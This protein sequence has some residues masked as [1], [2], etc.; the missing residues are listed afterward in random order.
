MV[1][2]AVAPAVPAGRREI[3]AWDTAGRPVGRLDYQLCHECRFGYIGNIAVA[4]GWRGHG[5]A[6]EMLHRALAHAPDHRWSTSRQTADGR[7][8]FAAMTEETAVH[9]VQRG[10]RC[11]HMTGRPVRV[12][13]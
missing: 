10:A 8:F 4:D 11:P 12:R 5:L 6:R 9:F 3:G 7:R 13:R 1:F 2:R